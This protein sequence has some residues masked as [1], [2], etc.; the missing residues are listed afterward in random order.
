[1]SRHS[2]LL[3]IYLIFGTNTVFAASPSRA[4]TCSLNPLGRLSFLGPVLGCGGLHLR[5]HRA[6]LSAFLLMRVITISYSEQMFSIENPWVKF[7]MKKIK[8]FLLLPA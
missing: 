3:P 2:E 5:G 7:K 8:N 1:M 6:C 4:L